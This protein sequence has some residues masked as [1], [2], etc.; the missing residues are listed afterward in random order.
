MWPRSRLAERLGS[1]H[2]I[3]QAPMAGAASPA[4]AAAVS[5]A[6][7]IGGYG[8]ASTPP[9]RL[10]GVIEEI[11]N[12]ADGG[13]FNL[14]LFTPIRGE[15]EANPGGLAEIRRALDA[16][17]Q[18]LGA[19]TT[20]D[21]VKLFD[22]FDEQ[23]DVVLEEKVPVVS[24]HFGAAEEHHLERL[25]SS[26]VLVISTATTVKEAQILEDAGVHAVIAQGLEAGGHQGTFERELGTRLSTLTL[27]PAVTDA[28]DLPVIAA[29]GITD[30]RGIA[31]ALALGAEGV[32]LGTAFLVCDEN[33][34]HGDYRQALVERGGEDT[35]MTSAISGRPARGLRNRLIETLEPLDRLR[36]PEHYSLTRRLRGAATRAGQPEYMT[37][38][39]G[40]G[41][42]NVTET[43]SAEAL[44]DALARETAE[45]LDRL[46]P[47][48]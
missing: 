21:P 6:G 31:A 27:L 24:L 33:E 25:L 16:P 35:V 29:G 20:P 36:Y 13:P 7:A 1:E 11:R 19:G 26:G 15:A 46:R 5:R 48:T 40:L 14:N 39:A 10:R 47:S 42:G 4:L 23:L 3:F 2:P 41:V 38:W 34:I 43:R 28:I 45:A 9:D 8:A 22:Q 37:L 12:G 32:Q 17:H 30:G 44:V 18:Y